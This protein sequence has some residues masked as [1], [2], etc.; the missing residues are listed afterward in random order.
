MV[1]RAQKI[2]DVFNERWPTCGREDSHKVTFRGEIARELFAE[3]NETFRD[4]IC[5]EVEELHKRDIE[6]YAEEDCPLR[7]VRTS[8]EAQA[9]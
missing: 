1:Q 6:A 2:N 7:T 9:E 3:E 5:E 8:A 4:K